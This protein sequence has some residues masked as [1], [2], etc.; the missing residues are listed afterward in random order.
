MITSSAVDLFELP[1][2]NTVVEKSSTVS[3][4]PLSVTDQG[5][6]EFVI[7]GSDD[8]IDA[9]HTLLHIRAKIIKRE[10]E[11][12]APVSTWFHSLFSQVDLFLQDKLITSSSTCYPYRAF[13]ETHLSYGS[14]AKNSQL[15]T[16]MYYHDTDLEEIIRTRKATK[17]YDM[18][19]RLHLD[20][21]HQNRYLLNHVG[22][23]LRLVR[24]TPE[25]NCLATSDEVSPKVSIESATLYVRKVKLNPQI[26]LA[27]AMVLESNPVKYPLCRTEIKIF[28]IG[29]GLT[30]VN[31]DQI[32]IGQVPSRIILSMVESAAFNGS[33]N[34]NPFDFKHFDVNFLSVY[35]DSDSVPT[36]PYCPNFTEG[37]YAREYLSLFQTLQQW[38]LN[39]GNEISYED[40]GNGHSFFV[41]DLAPTFHS[42]GLEL[43]KQGNVRLELKYKKPLPCN[44][45]ILCYAEFQNV[46]SITKDRSVFYD[47]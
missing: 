33:I 11:V 25:F 17:S 29:A 39:K 44:V 40:F 3:Y 26:Q 47:Y 22:M 27:H 43:R 20:F 19:G 37:H 38:S 36:Y 45:T 16:E 14:D 15:Q 23:K 34:K 28:S 9:S 1:L 7:S 12:V 5:P 2:T 18:V 41:F 31:R 35:V 6:L 8:Y 42:N 4:Q 30:D 13:I 10:E 32:F 24:S 46:L 21:F